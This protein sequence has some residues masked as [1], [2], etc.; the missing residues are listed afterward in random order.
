MGSRLISVQLRSFIN[1]VKM[2]TKNSETI[3]SLLGDAE[4]KFEQL[5]TAFVDSELKKLETEHQKL[6]KEVEKV[7]AELIKAEEQAGIKVYDH[8]KSTTSGVA[9]I[10]EVGA[11]STKPVDEP[12]KKKTNEKKPKAE[13]KSKAAAPV[14][15]EI[16]VGRLDLRVGRILDAKK[17]P[18]ADALYV[19]TI[20]LGEEKPRT[21]I[22]GLVKHIPLEQMINRVVVCLCNLKPVKMRGIESQAMVMCASTPEKVEIM[23]VPEDAKPGD[24]IIVDGFQHRPD[25]QLNPKKKVWETVAVDLKVAADGRAVYK[26]TVLMVEGG[27]GPMIA[28]TLRDVPVK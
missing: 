1:R 23:G 21:V 11:P 7:K 24:R 16:D 20:D 4:R 10:V 13:G 18:D 5:K 14:D 12:E 8:P 6:K 2:S 27:K 9:T 26:G 22:S 17:H 15:D 28:D 3:N 25:A 19:E